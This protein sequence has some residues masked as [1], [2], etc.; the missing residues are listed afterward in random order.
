MLTCD[1]SCDLHCNIVTCLNV[2]NLSRLSD[3]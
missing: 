1:V 3:L 2:Y